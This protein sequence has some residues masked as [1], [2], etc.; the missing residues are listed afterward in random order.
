MNPE[1]Q[2][3]TPMGFSVARWE[4]E[5]TLVVETTR[6]SFPWYNTA[7]VPQSEDVAIVER[8]ILSAD[9]LRLAH[10]ITVT[11]PATF[12]TPA[13]RT[14]EWMAVPGIEVRPFELDC[15]YN[16]WVVTG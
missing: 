12:T 9:E 13:R 10:E 1:A 11:D 14:S 4:N 16:P 6:V 15:D 7:G 3:A 5:R 8:F 2:P